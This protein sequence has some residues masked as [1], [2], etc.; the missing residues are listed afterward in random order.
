MATILVVDDAALTREHLGLI[1]QPDG[2]VVHA[3]ADGQSALERLH[4]QS[5]DLMITDLRMPNLDGLEL[6]HAVRDEEMPMGVI[7]LTGHGDT[8]IALEAMKA[9][10]DDFVTKP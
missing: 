5:F 4:Q 7:V 1:L 10:A 3:V 9:G 2:H 8:D 6:L